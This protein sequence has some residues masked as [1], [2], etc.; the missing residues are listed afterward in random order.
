[1]LSAPVVQWIERQPPKLEM[2]V[3]LPPGANFLDGNVVKS[4]VNFKILGK[5]RGFFIK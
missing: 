5:N 2:W 4:V 3:R 1:M